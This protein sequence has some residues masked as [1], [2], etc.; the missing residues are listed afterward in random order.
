M[1]P[2][3]IEKLLKGKRHCQKDKQQARDWEKIYTNPTSDTGIIFNICKELNKLYSRES[4]NPI[5]K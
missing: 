4:N 3:N 5:K 1:G 2:H